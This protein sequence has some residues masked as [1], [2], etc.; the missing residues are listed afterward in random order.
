MS[1]A[2]KIVSEL[3][4]ESRDILFRQLR[5][6]NVKSRKAMR[7]VRR[8]SEPLPLSYAQQRLWFLAQLEPDNTS[9]NMTRVVRMKGE[10]KID[11]LNRVMAEIFRRHESLRTRFPGEG[12]KPLQQI[13]EPV[14]VNIEVVEI[15]VEGQ[16]AGE[17]Q[18]V[19]E[20]R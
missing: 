6:R 14:P 18:I 19:D 2:G 12:G 3:A 20:A 17:R 1:D 9:Y 13:L 10:F 4:R 7:K 11:L 15:H 8:G 5:E 16:E